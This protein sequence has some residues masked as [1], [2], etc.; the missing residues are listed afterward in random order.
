MF[1]ENIFKICSGWAPVLFMGLKLSFGSELRLEPR[2]GWGSVFPAI[3][4]PE[5]SDPFCWSTGRAPYLMG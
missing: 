2:Q 4:L 1:C 5:C 3:C